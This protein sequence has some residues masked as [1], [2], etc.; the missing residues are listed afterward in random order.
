M[1][2]LFVAIIFM[3]GFNAIF[4]QTDSVKGLPNKKSSLDTFS[5]PNF[6]QYLKEVIV[7][8]KSPASFNKIDKQSYKSAQF[9]S[10]KGGSAIDVLKNLPSVTINGQ[11][12]IAIRGSTGF[13]VLI[14]G[15]AILTDAQTVLSQLP[16]NTIDNIELITAP[17]AKYDADGKA[18]IINIITKK[19]TNDGMGLVLNVQDGLPSTT[20]YH[21]L[22]NPIRFGGD[23]TLNIKQKKWDISIGTN[24]LRNDVNGRRDGDVL[25]K[26][27]L[28]NTIT[29]FPSSG[30]RSFDKYNYAARATISYAASANDIITVGLFAGK[31]FQARR[32]DIL[33][34]NSTSNLNR[35]P[36]IGFT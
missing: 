3:F 27:F 5:S 2:K 8:G 34:N 32:A 9:E 21:N 19:G 20:N 29:R 14:N 7:S 17:S 4:A 1:T 33:Y 15:K 25:T 30:E 22:E 28:N 16:A 24:F 31:K 26:N 18:G 23:I 12:D 11:G 13:L 10:A 35:Y 36:S 6:Y